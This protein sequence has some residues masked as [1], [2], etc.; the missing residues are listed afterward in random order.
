M[1]IERVELSIFPGREA[2][3]EAAMQHGAAL[4]AGA[5]GCTSV[6]L[7]RGV[8]RPSC[9]LLQ[10]HWNSVAD[11]TAFTLT[12]EFQ[13]FRQLAGPFFAERP[14]MEHFQPMNQAA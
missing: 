6:A 2:E 9:Y 5:S 1:V 8:E 10:L 3:F 14:A 11:H 4:L 7:A 13:S 12:S